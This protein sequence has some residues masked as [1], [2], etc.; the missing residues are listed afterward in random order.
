MVKDE[1]IYMSKKGQLEFQVISEFI[2]GRVNRKE[3][4]ELLQVRERTISRLARRVELKGILGVIHA[5][6]TTLPRIKS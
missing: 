1:G 2:Q 5:I 6:G 3:A 4:A